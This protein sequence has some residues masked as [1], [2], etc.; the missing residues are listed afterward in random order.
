MDRCV[1]ESADRCAAGTAALAGKTRYSSPR[2]VK[3]LGSDIW[4]AYICRFQQ[5]YDRKSCFGG[6]KRPMFSHVRPRAGVC[7]LGGGRAQPQG[8]SAHTGYTAHCCHTK[9]GV[10]ADICPFLPR[11]YNQISLIPMDASPHT[12]THARIHSL[13]PLVGISHISARA[14]PGSTTEEA[15][16]SGG[17]GLANSRA[18]V[19]SSHSTV[20]C[21]H[22]GLWNVSSQGAFPWRPQTT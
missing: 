10:C 11:S 4:D 18:D 1:V 13:F 3:T 19:A 16:V 8:P 15:S 9:A 6:R 14:T 20:V 2:W 7:A 17:C 12:H 21:S 5:H 22:L